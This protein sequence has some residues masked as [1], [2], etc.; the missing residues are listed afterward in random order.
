MKEMPKHL[1]QIKSQKLDKE[2][3]NFVS[4]RSMGFNTDHVPPKPPEAIYDLTGGTGSYCYMA[5]EITLCKP[6]NEKVGELGQHPVIQPA[7]SPACSPAPS[8]LRW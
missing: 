4:K 7:W 8:P 3:N 1:K 5:P 6:Y 2:L